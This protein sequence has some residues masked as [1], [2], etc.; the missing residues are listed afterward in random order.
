[1]IFYVYCKD[2]SGIF[3]G[4]LYYDFLLYGE[5]LR[6]SQH[7]ENRRNLLGYFKPEWKL[8]YFNSRE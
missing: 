6:N 3:Q 8:S 2:L 7:N 5:K 1:M 4:T